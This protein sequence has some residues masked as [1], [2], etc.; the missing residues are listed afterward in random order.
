MKI[1]EQKLC[2]L[3]KQIWS[4]IRADGCILR[5]AQSAGLS[6]YTTVKVVVPDALG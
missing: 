6:F 1:Y 4:C 3:G 5:E 2:G